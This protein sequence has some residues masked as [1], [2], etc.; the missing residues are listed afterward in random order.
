MFELK[1]SIKGFLN[2][3]YWLERKEDWEWTNVDLLVE[4]DIAELFFNMWFRE[5]S[6]FVNVL[7]RIVQWV[8]ITKQEA[9]LMLNLDSINLIKFLK[10]FLQNYNLSSESKNKDK[11]T[12]LDII[13]NLHKK[14]LNWL[15]DLEKK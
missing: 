6:T 14:I 15:C 5:P 3:E 10:L 11:V 7:E 8:E 1:S 12:A 9:D 4:S 13:I 2:D